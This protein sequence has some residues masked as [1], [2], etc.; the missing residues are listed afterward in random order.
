MPL[1]W[2][3]TMLPEALLLA[4]V[5][6]LAGGVLGALL[7]RSLLPQ[8]LVRQRTPRGMAAAAMAGALAAL[9]VVVPIRTHHGW[10]AELTLAPAAAAPTRTVWVTARL[11]ADADATAQ[12]AEW[13]HVLAWQG[14]DGT[15]SSD[16]V[17]QELA[18]M[19]RVGDRLW[20]STSPVPVSGQWKS[21]LRLAT[22]TSLQSV[23]I[24][25]PA[26]TAIPAAEIPAAAH[27]TR[28]FVT[29]HQLLQREAV[30]GSAGVKSAAYI[31]LGV[32]GLAWL[33]CIGLGCRRLERVPPAS[34]A[35]RVRE[36]VASA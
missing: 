33:L 16:Q 27:V 18:P 1:P 35:A 17:G 14:G 31:G 7:G 10:S 26:D 4:V 22:P 5:A 32:V 9:A 2:H 6:G 24:Y 19:R 21:F 25:L 34:A 30:G 28:A 3:R 8:P 11:S 12:H 36:R 13:F 15:W 20:R 23:P 29:D